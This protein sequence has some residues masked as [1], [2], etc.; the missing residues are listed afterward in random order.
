MTVSTSTR[1]AIEK[2]LIQTLGPSAID[3]IV[4]REGLDHADEDALFLEVVMKRSDQPLT[5]HKSIDARVAVSDALLEISDAR[6]PYMRFTHPDDVPVD[7]ESPEP[8]STHSH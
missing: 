5:A 4:I 6:F 1:C 3:H 2:A 8:H 7:D